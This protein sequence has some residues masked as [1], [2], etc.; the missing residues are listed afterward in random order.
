LLNIIDEATKPKPV[1]QVFKR[2]DI[3]LLTPARF[4]IEGDG[5]LLV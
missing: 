4:P 3:G 5:K 2:G 1:E